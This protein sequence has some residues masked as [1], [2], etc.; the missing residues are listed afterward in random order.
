[1]THGIAALNH[2]GGS[3]P[4]SLAKEEKVLQ[5]NKLTDLSSSWWKREHG[6]YAGDGN[7]L[8][9]DSLHDD[10][11]ALLFPVL[12]MGATRRS[13]KTATGFGITGSN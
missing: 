9:G 5:D 3:C 13:M 8:T 10:P 4:P 12:R 11:I 2:L 6:G 7:R 1:L